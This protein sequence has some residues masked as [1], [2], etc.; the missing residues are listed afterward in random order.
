LYRLQALGAKSSSPYDRSLAITRRS[1]LVAISLAGMFK[2]R[3]RYSR[4]K[5][6]LASLRGKIEVVRLRT[7]CRGPR[8]QR[9]LDI[10]LTC[11][12]APVLVARA[13]EVVT[14][15][16]RSETRMAAEPRYP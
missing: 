12:D 10:D 8:A 6:S 9:S 15:R 2:R 4:T 3:E 16:N 14:P 11:A 5:P 1:G 13:G 7:R